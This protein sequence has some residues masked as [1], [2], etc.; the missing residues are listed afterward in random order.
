MERKNRSIAFRLVIGGV[1]LVLIPLIIVGVISYHASHN[2]LITMSMERTQDDSVELSRLTNTILQS[3]LNLVK[4]L[5]AGE[6][7]I[8]VSTIIKEKGWENAPDE[9]P[10]LFENLKTK[11]KRMD[12]HYEGVFVTDEKGFIYTGVNDDGTEL[13]GISL[14]ET[15]HFKQSKSSG[16]AVLSE[17]SRSKKSDVFTFTACA[18]VKSGSG[19]FLGVVG[20]V[21]KTNFLMDLIS[22]KKIGQTGYAY[23]VDSKS[24]TNIH[25]LKENI[26]S[27]DLNKTDGM[28]N[29]SQRLMNG[30]T[31]VDT[32]RYKGAEKVSGFSPVGINH[33]MIVTVQDKAEVTA[34][35]VNTRNIIAMVSCI[36]ALV[37]VF[38]VWFSVKRIVMPINATVESLKDIA[39]GKG[40]LTMR[41]QAQSKDEIGE[42]A[43]WFNLFM[44]KLQGMMRQISQSIDMLTASSSELS[45][46]SDKMTSTT[47]KTSDLS[48]SVTEAA[49]LLSNNMQS[50][51]S[52]MVQTCRNTD[53]VAKS[54][55]EMSSTIIEIAKNSETA[56]N[57]S[58]QAAAQAATSSSQMAQM[59]DAA[60][61]IGRVVETITEISEQVN[62]LALNATIEAAR[63]GEAGKGFAVVANEIKELAKQTA[64]AT[65]DIET[66]IEAIQQVTKETISRIDTITGVIAEVNHVVT[67]IAVA[68]EEQSVSTS[69]IATNVTQAARSIEGIN[70]NV[71]KSSILASDISKDIAEVNTSSNE[72]ANGNTQINI[73]YKRLASLADDLR[74]MVGQFRI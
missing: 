65:R 12:N 31:G 3:E 73:A 28:E 74:S 26:L 39:Q 51:A 72:I 10:L 27:L 37:T 16:E 54:A 71:G 23:M 17:I 6:R 69:E 18:A 47:M 22:D 32:Y 14:T 38:L 2:A 55:E 64:E 49:R 58:Q 67:G 8:K 68:V 34:S 53:V 46:V 24:I 48:S 50:A 42:L 43:T 66:K 59:G 15:A 33:W 36:A 25:P 44:D 30:E 11:L 61:A 70:E 19:E 29:I 57:I 13:K 21:I 52:A 45:S 7:Q 4:S 35:A 5:A 1:A 41:L 20:T 62:L 60:Q 40:D 56:R 9:I 63:A